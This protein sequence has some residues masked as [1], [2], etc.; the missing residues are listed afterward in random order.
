MALF[1]SKKEE[2]AVVK[3]TAKK[4]VEKKASP[5]VIAKNAQFSSILL[6]P[7]VT[8]KAHMVS[9]KGQY[10]FFADISANKIQI[11]QA[12]EQIYGV[13]VKSVSTSITNP[14]KR[15]RGKQVGYTKK[16]K[17]AIVSLRSGETITLFEGA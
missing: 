8:E 12:V 1:E 16:M 14:K 3:K 7:I 2:K 9:E 5:A 11:R 10:A 17:K 4:T 13:H 6:R 15:I